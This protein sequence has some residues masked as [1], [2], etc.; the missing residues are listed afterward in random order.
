MTY[1]GKTLQIASTLLI[2]TLVITSVN[3][4]TLA[5]LNVNK[6]SEQLIEGQTEASGKS[7][8]GMWKT[9]QS[10]SAPHDELNDLGVP[11]PTQSAMI[12]LKF[13]DDSTGTMDWVIMSGPNCE[14][15]FSTDDF[16]RYID[17]I[18]EKCVEKHNIEFCLGIKNQETPKLEGHYDFTY[19]ASLLAENE[20]GDLDMTGPEDDEHLDK[21][22]TAYLSYRFLDN[23]L[24][25]TLS[26]DQEQIE[27]SECKVIAG[28][29]PE[30]RAT[31]F[32]RSTVLSP[33]IIP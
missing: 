6:L 13:A 20:V 27:L 21:L 9:C 3:A 24:Q 32:A 12:N 17:A 22:V 1:I 31:D 10:F 28:D 30:R 26:C 14:K 18:Y 33:S 19:Q 16:S 11:Y 7:L 23:N 8:I 29:A 2:Q 5:S 4:K 15:I 25:I